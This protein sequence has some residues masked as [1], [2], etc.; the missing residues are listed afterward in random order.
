MAELTN[1]G[2]NGTDQQRVSMYQHPPNINK[3]QAVLLKL[4]RVHQSS[5]RRNAKRKA[6]LGKDQ[7]TCKSF[8][9]PVNEGG[10]GAAWPTWT[11]V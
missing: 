11:E 10:L 9:Q 8:N 2:F 6:Q 1:L 7:D 3:E 4:E 5:T